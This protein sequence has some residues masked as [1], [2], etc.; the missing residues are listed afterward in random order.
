M[1]VTRL[2]SNRRDRRAGV[3]PIVGNSEPHP[4]HYGKIA[5][6][7]PPSCRAEPGKREPADIHTAHR[8]A[9]QLWPFRRPD[10]LL[11]EDA[12]PWE[13]ICSLQAACSNDQEL[14]KS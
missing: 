14:P 7:I 8:P 13:T 3:G 4:E 2:P 12:I 6:W 1:T 5:L 9:F 10:F 11:G